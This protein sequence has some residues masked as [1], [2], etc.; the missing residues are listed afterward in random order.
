MTP[1]AMTAAAARALL[2]LLDAA[3]AKGL[4]GAMGAPLEL[5]AAPELDG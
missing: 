2:V 3:P 4:A 1:P 5:G